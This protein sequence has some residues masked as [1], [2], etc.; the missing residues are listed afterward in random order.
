MVSGLTLADDWAGR[1]SGHRGDDD[2]R[3]ASGKSGTAGTEI[4]ASPFC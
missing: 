4:Y 2:D 3:R 1:S